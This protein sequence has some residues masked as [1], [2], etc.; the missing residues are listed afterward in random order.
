MIHLRDGLIPLKIRVRLRPRDLIGKRAERRD[1][2]VV[3]SV[4]AIPE[5]RPARFVH[6]AG[7]NGKGSTCAMI[8]AG[9]RA[10]G[11]RTGLYTSPHLS[12][13]TERIRLDGEPVDSDLF[14]SAFEAVRS[15]AEDLLAGP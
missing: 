2:G 12:Q 4:I 6:V 3:G 8:E 7:T 1:F 13:P 14:V 10:D 5:R 9:L 15:V 11:R